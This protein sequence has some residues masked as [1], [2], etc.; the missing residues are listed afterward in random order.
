MTT[1]P[2]GPGGHRGVWI[3]EE[4]KRGERERSLRQAILEQ[5][6]VA[7]IPFVPTGIVVIDTALRHAGHKPTEFPKRF[8]AG[9]N[10]Q[11]VIGP[12]VAAIVTVMRVPVVAVESHHVVLVDR[13]HFLAEKVAAV[14]V[15]VI[16]ATN[17]GFT[18]NGPVVLRAD[19]IEVFVGFLVVVGLGMELD[20]FIALSSTGSAGCEQRESDH[21]SEG[22]VHQVAGTG[23]E[24]HHGTLT[25]LFDRN[26]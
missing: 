15:A 9:K 13:D 10:R 23:A 20:V 4:V 8:V 5:I 19:H 22:C 18:R 1:P 16:A 2:G 24:L 12:E 3:R 26:Q 14:V 21:Q 25:F 11:E 6:D 7:R 17:L